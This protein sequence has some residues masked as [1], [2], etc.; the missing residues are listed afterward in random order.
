MRRLLSTAVALMLV[1]LPMV[2]AWQ[3]QAQPARVSCATDPI[4]SWYHGATFKV[5]KGCVTA[6]GTATHVRSHGADVYFD[7][8]PN[9][10]S[11][12]LLNA[13]NV[14]IGGVIPVGITGRSRIRGKLVN[15]AHVQLAGPWI[16][17]LTK[18]WNEI[19]SASYVRVLAAPSVPHAP[20]P[21]PLP[22]PATFTVRAAVTPSTMSYNAYPTLTAYTSPGASCTASV[23]YSTGRAPVSFNGVP[24]TVPSGGSVSWSWHEE[25][26]GDG[27]VGTVTCTL[28]GRTATAQ[29]SFAVVNA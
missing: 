2:Q 12:H 9:P 10:A 17:Y 22:Q 15:G 11:R 25:T 18:G 27:G 13:H 7:L 26:K 28:N 4:A 8:K 1:V 20:P 19:M 5:L 14:L 16:H 3:I 6:T 23:V 29:A 24:R 21:T